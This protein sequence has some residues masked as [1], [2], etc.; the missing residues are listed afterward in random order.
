MELHRGQ[1]QSLHYS[2]WEKQHSLDENMGLR[3]IV[4]ALQL[5]L[6]LLYMS[7]TF[8]RAVTSASHP[9]AVFVPLVQNG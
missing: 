8:F 5:S 4:S 6:P 9:Q 7:E 3:K 1:Q 2:S